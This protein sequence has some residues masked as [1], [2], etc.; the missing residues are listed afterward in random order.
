[1]SRPPPVHVLALHVRCNV[2]CLFSVLSIS[3]SPRQHDEVAT[4][5]GGP[6][7]LNASSAEP[8]D[9]D[10]RHRLAHPTAHCCARSR[11]VHAR[12]PTPACRRLLRYRRRALGRSPTTAW[13]RPRRL[14]PRRLPT[15]ARTPARP[16]RPTTVRR[17][18]PRVPPDLLSDALHAYTE[19]MWET[20]VGEAS[21]SCWTDTTSAR[22]SSD[23]RAWAAPPRG[24][25]TG[26]RPSA[27]AEALSVA[28]TPR[29]RRRLPDASTALSTPC[30]VVHARCLSFPV[31][32]LVI[33]LSRVRR[34]L[35][36]SAGS[37]EVRVHLLL[38]ARHA[39]TAQRHRATPLLADGAA[40]ALGSPTRLIR[41]LVGGGR[42]AGYAAGAYG[43]AMDAVRVEADAG[44]PARRRARDGHRR[45]LAALLR[46]DAVRAA[47]HARATARDGGTGRGRGETG[48]AAGGRTAETSIARAQAQNRPRPSARP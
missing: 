3:A 19:Q 35:A 47:A 41:A 5:A 4:R 40:G 10:G 37:A 8:R 13:A 27:R 34:S 1:M 28:W 22:T 20:T 30:P 32:D 48:A 39:G 14:S 38:R 42:E 7:A 29:R 25:I 2:Q 36:A 43:R 11:H 17:A 12:A 33:L 31:Y 15:P 6:N 44:A 16:L 26:G 23:G 24:V 9:L 18:F 21:R 45:T 46:R